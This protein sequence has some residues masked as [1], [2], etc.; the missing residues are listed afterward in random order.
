MVSISR[1]CMLKANTTPPSLRTAVSV[2]CEGK[3][4]VLSSRPGACRG[5]SRHGGGGGMFLGPA[6]C[7]PATGH[8]A[9]SRVQTDLCRR[10]QLLSGM[11]R[12]HGILLSGFGCMMQFLAWVGSALTGSV[13]LSSHRTWV[14]SLCSLRLQGPYSSVNQIKH[15]VWRVLVGL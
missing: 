11:E 10:Q 1:S 5:A 3:H 2:V 12:N 15:L 7:K 8:R 9:G 4:G 6:V 14:T 13:P